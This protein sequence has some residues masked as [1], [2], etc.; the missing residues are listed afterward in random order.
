MLIA[1]S[2]QYMNLLSFTPKLSHPKRYSTMENPSR[3]RNG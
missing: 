3:N 1:E 2:D